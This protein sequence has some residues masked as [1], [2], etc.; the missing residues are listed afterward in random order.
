[1]KIGKKFLSLLMGVAV[2]MFTSHSRKLTT[3]LNIILQITRL[4]RVPAVM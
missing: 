1:M 2:F 4:A 3:N